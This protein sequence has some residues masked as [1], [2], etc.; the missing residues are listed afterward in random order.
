MLP[1]K[2]FSSFWADVLAK[3]SLIACG[4]WCPTPL[5]MRLLLLEVTTDSSPTGC[6]CCLQHLSRL[7]RLWVPAPNSQC[8]AV[9]R[10]MLLVIWSAPPEERQ[11]RKLIVEDSW[12]AAWRTPCECQACFH[13]SWD[14]STE[15]CWA[16]MGSFVEQLWCGADVSS[17]SRHLY[18]LYS[19]ESRSEAGVPRF[20]FQELCFPQCFYQSL[21]MRR[22]RCPGKLLCPSW[23][24]TG[25]ATY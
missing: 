21:A 20:Q 9:M 14:A 8:V 24:V 22:N 3:I 10:S 16:W 19:K 17:L 13:R 6:F 25:I 11:D 15:I 18:R 4:R 7:G 5:V 12:Q 2:R 23:S 1:C